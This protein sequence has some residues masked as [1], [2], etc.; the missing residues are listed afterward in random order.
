VTPINPLLLVWSAVNRLSTGENI[1]GADER[2]SALQAL[3]A[4]TIDAAWQ[5]FQEDNRGFIE[6]GKYADL[7]VLSDNPLKQPET[8]KDIKVLETIVGGR[9]IYKRN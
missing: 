3:R 8:I 7:V 6:V 9:T 5:I 2:I 4:T 1:I